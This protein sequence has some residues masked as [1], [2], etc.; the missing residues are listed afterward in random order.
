MISAQ[1]LSLLKQLNLQPR[2]TMRA[3][4]WTS[5]EFGLIGAQEYVK[6]HGKELSKIIAAFESDIG[7]FRPLGL[8]FSGTDEAGCIVQEVLALFSQFNTTKYRKMDEVGSDI[9]YLIEKGVPGISLNTENE[10]YFWFHH[11]EG[12]MLTVQDS[13]EMDLCTAVWAAA[14]YVLADLSVALP[15]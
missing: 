8:D 13:G 7:T 2:R 12:D 4:L 11:S 3:V 15:R 5:E 1:T 10:R 14:S 6:R 9:G